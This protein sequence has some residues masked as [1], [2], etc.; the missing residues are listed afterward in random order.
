MSV[1][2]KLHRVVIE[3]TP[4]FKLAKIQY[5]ATEIYT[6]LATLITIYVTYTLQV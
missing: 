1:L 3:M 5:N 6:I 4:K 2:T